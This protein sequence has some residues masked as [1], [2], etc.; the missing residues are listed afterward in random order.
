[1]SSMDLFRNLISSLPV[2]DLLNAGF[3]AIS[4]LGRV[5]NNPVWELVGRPDIWTMDQTKLKE[6][7]GKAM[8][9]TF[10]HHYDNCDFYRNYCKDSGD[11]RPEDIHSIEDIINIPQIP[12]EA[13]KTGVISSVPQDRIHTVVTTSGTS[14]SVS[15]LVRD[16]GSLLRMGTIIINYIINVG[17]PL[18]LKER[19]DGSMK[20]LLKYA[21]TNI[22]V[23]PLLPEPDE[24]S[25]WFTN[26]LFAPFSSILRIK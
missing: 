22:Y 14:G 25:T 21:L 1:M 23:A 26:A 4:S 11:I 9:Y 20:D 12:A 24:A 6:L 15:Y 17:A 5:T 18:V 10:K 2:R 16:Y 8:K 19:F 7:Q 13:F 3:G